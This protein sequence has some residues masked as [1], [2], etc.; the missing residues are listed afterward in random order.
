MKILLTGGALDAAVLLRAL[1]HASE[2]QITHCADGAYAFAELLKN[3]CDWAII[4]S[5]AVSGGDKDIARI[6]RAM[7]TETGGFPP[8]AVPRDGS[9]TGPVAPRACSAEWT[10]EGVLQL[11]CGLHALVKDAMAPWR[12]DTGCAGEILFEYHAPCAKARRRDG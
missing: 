7:G 4:N 5:R 2:H 11:H 1:A 12:P 8:V 10:K 3:G 9:V 6:I